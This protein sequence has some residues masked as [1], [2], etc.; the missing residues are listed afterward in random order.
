MREPELCASD[1]FMS[2]GVPI[3]Q[4]KFSCGSPACQS[5]FPMGTEQAEVED[6]GSHFPCLSGR[7]CL[8]HV[9]PALDW[10][11]VSVVY[12]GEKGGKS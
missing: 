6:G 5:A 12:S 3:Q 4:R 11:S 2:P 1:R 8:R 10:I 9:G 7:T